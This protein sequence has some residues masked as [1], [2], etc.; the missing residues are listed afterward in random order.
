MLANPHIHIRKTRSAEF[1]VS[2]E[3]LNP[4][5]L[6]LGRPRG[7]AAAVGSSRSG[8]G[9]GPGQAVAVDGP[10]MAQHSRE[11]D[12][13]SRQGDADHDRG[14][15]GGDGGPCPDLSSR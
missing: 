15:A 2:E 9:Q 4:G 11:E 1:L 14:Q 12:R 3:T 8:D 7:R 6:P 13:G 5:P 10:E